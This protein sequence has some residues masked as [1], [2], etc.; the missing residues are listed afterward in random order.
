MQVKRKGIVLAGGSGTRL[1]P[2]TLGVSKQLLPIFDKPMI[3]YPLS[4]LIMAG[5]REVLFI[6]TPRDS[7]AFQA[8]L[9][10]GSSLG[11]SFTYA[12]Q[13]V[14]RG[15]AD[16]Y[17]IGRKFLAGAPSVMV[18]GDNLHFG[19]GF[20]ALLDS[21]D[22]ARGASI[23]A[24][25]VRNPSSFGIVE[26]DEEYR[27][28]SLEEKPAKPRSHWAITGL[29]FMDERAPDLAEEV[30]PSARGELEIVSML[31]RYLHL[32]CL[33]VERLHRG[34]AWLDAGTHES[35]HQ[36]ADF[37][38]TLQ[39]RQGLLICSP[40]ELAYRKGYISLGQLDAAA[41]KLSHSTYGEALKAVVEQESRH[42]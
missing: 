29:Y 7:A 34:F 40:E 38:K 33:N 20:Q 17:R 3:Y 32:G 23:F 37:V 36:A 10:D 26:L 42:D 25:L 5:V 27:P 2:L 18:L 9:G 21:A 22:S 39:D 13:D 8:L 35:L 41:G 12:I 19:H 24:A 28:V 30:R 4:T 1:F 15:L 11:M 14:P 16:A 31:E 6:T